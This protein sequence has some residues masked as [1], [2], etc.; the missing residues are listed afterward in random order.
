MEPQ[1]ANLASHAPE[2]SA[3]TAAPLAAPRERPRPSAAAA[4]EGCRD[5]SGG[6][7]NGCGPVAWADVDSQLGALAAS[8]IRGTS[9]LQDFAADR[10][11]SAFERL[12]RARD[13]DVAP[14]SSSGGAWDALLTQLVDARVD[15]AAKEQ[16][17][18][19]REARREALR[20]E[21]ECAREA[22]RNLEAELQRATEE[23]RRLRDEGARQRKEVGLRTQLCQARLR[24]LQKEATDLRAA[25]GASP[26]APFSAQAAAPVP[27]LSTTAASLAF[28]GSVGGAPT[29]PDA[30]GVAVA[31]AA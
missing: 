22:Q 31:S 30:A 15:L 10:I 9:Y 16:L 18:R 14:R 23:C 11:C 4:A 28:D 24:S 21:N 20:R 5:A 27:R 17:Q 13:V 1:F 29:S 12:R 2:A 7:G 8:H 25:C 19:V 3:S 26:L 6:D